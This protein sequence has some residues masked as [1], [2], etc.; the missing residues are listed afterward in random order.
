MSCNISVIRSGGAV[1]VH[2][3]VPNSALDTLS[4]WKDKLYN[5]TD[6]SKSSPNATK[7]TQ[8]KISNSNRIEK[9][10]KIVFVGSPGDDVDNSDSTR[11]KQKKQNNTL[12]KL[13][14]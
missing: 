10:C 7:A 2:S 11:K 14:Y 4:K 8:G 5:D 12:G 13:L 9:G 3:I 1:D 6:V